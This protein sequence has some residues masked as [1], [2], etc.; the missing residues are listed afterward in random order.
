[1][2]RIVKANL[3]SMIGRQTRYTILLPNPDLNR[4]FR[5]LL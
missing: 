4:L 1:M 2:V 3:T 5:I